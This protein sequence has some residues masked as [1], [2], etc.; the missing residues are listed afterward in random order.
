MSRLLMS[1]KP[2]GKLVCSLWGIML[3]G[4]TLWIPHVEGVQDFGF[5]S[6]T[7]ALQIAAVLIIAT[8]TIAI[9]AQSNLPVGTWRNGVGL[10]SAY[11]LYAMM[12][13]FVSPVPLL[14]LWKGWLVVLDAMLVAITIAQVGEKGRELLFNMVIGFLQLLVVLVIASAIIWP[15]TALKPVGGLVGGH[16]YGVV[17]K[18]NPNEIGF[19]SAIIAIVALRRI[20][21][22][23]STRMKFLYISMLSTSLVVLFMSQA[24]TSVIAFLLAMTFLGFGIRKLRVLVVIGILML[25]GVGSYALISGSSLGVGEVA[26]TYME[27]GV[28]QER[29][30]SMSGRTH[31]WERGFEAFK[32]S[33]FFGHGFEAGVRFGEIRSHMH[34]AHMQILVNTGLFGYVLWITFVGAVGIQLFML[35]KNQSFRNNTREGRFHFEIMAVYG[36]MLLRT[37]TGSVLVFHQY[38][39]VILMAIQV[40]LFAARRQLKLPAVREEC[41]QSDPIVVTKQR[42]LKKAVLRPRLN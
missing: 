12:T 20:P 30:E 13:A 31:L 40:Y 15:D 29:L 1:Q 19:I 34:N 35:R 38:S 22:A 2:L 14:S 39:L 23:V 32:Q 42:I 6:S 21:D 18:L 9:L 7:Y 27:R 8:C 36:V 4:M 11:G 5:L 17:P 3:V 25:G 28:S 16:L 33:P 24:R 26:T 41:E 37:I 10:M